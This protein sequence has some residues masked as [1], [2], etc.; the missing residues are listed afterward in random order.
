V[1]LPVDTP[2]PTPSAPKPDINWAGAFA[3]AFVLL[4][5]LTLA[6]GGGYVFYA[7]IR[8]VS[9]DL[10]YGEPFIDFPWSAAYVLLGIGWAVGP[11]ALLITGLI[12]MQKTAPRN[13]RPAA[14]WVGAVAA[15]TAI[16]YLI[17]HDYGLLFSAYPKDLDGTPLGPSRWVPG[18]PYW[19]ALIATGGQLAV[20]AVMVALATASTRRAATAVTPDTSA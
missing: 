19:Q 20:G 9:I 12:H 2:A 5:S 15:G 14:A 4:Y 3:V 6:A 7:S 11:V 16:G 10:G 8:P 18:T 1:E 17:V 13:W